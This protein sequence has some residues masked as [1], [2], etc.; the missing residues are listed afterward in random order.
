M[1]LEDF[2]DVIIIGGSYAGLGAA[3]AL[4]RALRSVLVVDNGDPCNK[5]TPYSHNFLTQDGKTPRE[6]TGV[7]KRQVQTYGS[8]AFFNGM[9]TAA[10]TTKEGFEVMVETG[11]TFKGKKLVLATGIKDILPAIPGFAESW[12]IS[13][14]HCPYCHGYEVRQQKTG[15]LAN[16]DLAYE[17]SALLSNWTDDLT[18]YTNGLSTLRESQLIKLRQNNIK[19]VETRLSKLEH[20]EGYIYNLILE[21]G[22]QEAADVLYAKL[23]FVQRSTIPLIL[24]CS[25]TEEGYIKTD[26]A[27]KTTVPGVFACGD[28]ASKIR[29]VANAVAMGTT[30]GIMVNKQLIE[31]EF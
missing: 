26:S 14:L 25:L 17:M 16:G 6:I 21:D 28:N 4:G 5:Q 19:I 20:L 27:Q 15:L 31:E 8:V 11:E 12:G 22:S 9:A 30:T 2:Y 7:A 18:V 10:G 1:I 3:M 29:T 23:P 24:G 13:V